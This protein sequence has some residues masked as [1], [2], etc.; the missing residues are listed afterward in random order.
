MCAIVVYV[1]IDGRRC[2]TILDVMAML[3]EKNSDG[4]SD[5]SRSDRGY[6]STLDPQMAPEGV[7]RHFKHMQ[8]GHPE[9]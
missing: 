5:R 3:K 7:R 2:K 8:G 6:P 1:F 4:A 9:Q